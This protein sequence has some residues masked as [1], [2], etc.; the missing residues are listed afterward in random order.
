MTDA[1]FENL[2]ESIKFRR[3]FNE[4]CSRAGVFGQH[5]GNYLEGHG[6]C[7]HCGARALDVGSE[8]AVMDEYLS[9]WGSD[10]EYRATAANDPEFLAVLATAE[11]HEHW[12]ATAIHYRFCVEWRTACGSGN[13]FVVEVDERA[14]R[15]RF[16]LVYPHA[17]I[18]SV[19]GMG[20]VYA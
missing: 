7:S 5:S 20:E 12:N 17:D 19:T 4:T 8:Q 6:E 2:L 11:Y 14:A 15:A 18:E 1:L 9:E 16:R 13:A 10:A 3:E